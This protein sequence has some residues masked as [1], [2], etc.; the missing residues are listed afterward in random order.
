MFS[1]KEPPCVGNRVTTL[2]LD[3]P[4]MQMSSAV[5][6]SASFKKAPLESTHS[7]SGRGYLL[8]FLVTSQKPFGFHIRAGE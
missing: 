1:A 4:D 2:N 6:G 3:Y 5:I 8:S 7:A